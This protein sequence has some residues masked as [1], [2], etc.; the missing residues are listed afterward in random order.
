MADK[1]YWETIAELDYL[2]WELDQLRGQLNTK[3]AS[4]INM[5]ID[6]STGFAEHKYQENKTAI[7]RCVRRIVVLKKRLDMDTGNLEAFLRES[8]KLDRRVVKVVAK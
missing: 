8:K 3:P 1:Q 2:H 5:M 4:A 6:H 7:E